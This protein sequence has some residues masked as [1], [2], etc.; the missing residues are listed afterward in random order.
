MFLSGVRSMFLSPVQHLKIP[1]EIIFQVAKGFRGRS[2]GCIKMA[3]ARAMKA[4]QSSY[5]HRHQR[6]TRYRAY[7]IGKINSAVRE[8]DFTYR[9]FWGTMCQSG[10]HLDRKMLAT[11]AET[12][13][14]SFKVVVDEMKRLAYYPPTKIR[15]V[16]GL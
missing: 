8:Y 10:V 16:S 1:R 13:P 15:D 14:V 5:T 3:R 12:E 4:L 7:W 2:K 9:L 11:L 6:A